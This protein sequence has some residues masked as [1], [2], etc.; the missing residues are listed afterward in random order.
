MIIEIVSFRLPEG[1]TQEDVLADA[2]AVVA[3]WQ[4]DPDLIRKHFA[5]AEDGSHAGIYVWPSR[6]AAQRAHDADWIARFQART[7]TVPSFSYFDVFMLIDNEAGT[8]RE[9]PID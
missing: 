5:R 6:E 4:S 2:R 8:V 1:T 3:Q 7:G 9:F